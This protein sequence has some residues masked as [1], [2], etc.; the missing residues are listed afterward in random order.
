VETASISADELIAAGTCA[1]VLVL[2]GTLVYAIRQVSEAK[3]LRR[4]QFRP[5]VT[6]SFHFRSN[7]AFI[8]VKNLGKTTAHDVRIRFEPKLVS[9][10]VQQDELDEIAM[11]N[12]PI[13]TLV[14]GDER[15]ALFDQTP[16]RLS[17][18][19]LPDRHRAFVEYTDHRGESLGPDEFV[20]DFGNLAGGRLPD[21]GIHE[22]AEAAIKIEKRLRG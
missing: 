11:F 19:A 18:E 15:L 22:L 13:P 5:W 3:E 17:D 16:Q 20:L 6:V 21:K 10:L 1:T 12:E 4:E 9:A 8:V 7:I 2:T 14:P